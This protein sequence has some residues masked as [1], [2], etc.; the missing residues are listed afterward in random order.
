MAD[1][2]INLF[3]RPFIESIAGPRRSKRARKAPTRSVDTHYPD[4]DVDYE[5][6]AERENAYA[7]PSAQIYAWMASR[8]VPQRQAMLYE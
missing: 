2:R 5:G 8:P 6:E 1:C 7:E 4:D 3:S